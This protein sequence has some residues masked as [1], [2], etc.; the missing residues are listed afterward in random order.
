MK[1]PDVIYQV[2][3]K[4]LELL[5]ELFESHY[6]AFHEEFLEL[7]EKYFEGDEEEIELAKKRAMLVLSLMKLK[8]DQNVK[9]LKRF[10]KLEQYASQ[11]RLEQK[12]LTNLGGVRDARSN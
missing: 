12:T 10:F 1:N 3:N 6:P 7:V 4:V 9:E 11:E 2:S 5:G 8:F